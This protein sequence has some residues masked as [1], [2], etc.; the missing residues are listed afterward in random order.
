MDNSS[1]FP[2]LSS[3][4]KCRICP[5]AS[6]QPASRPAS[7]R[8]K[9]RESGW[10][11][12]KN[13]GRTAH[14]SCPRHRWNDRGTNQRSLENKNNKSE[15]RRRETERG[16]VVGAARNLLLIVRSVLERRSYTT[17]IVFYTV[18]FQ[19]RAFLNTKYIAFFS[20]S[21]L[22]L[23]RSNRDIETNF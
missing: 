20:P 23:P 6:C 11:G 8:E 21:F 19:L 12:T 18:S 10:Q 22:S 17:T 3:R 5:L 9:E 1:L 13:I 4:K 7:R 14:E 15:R 16:S 2:P